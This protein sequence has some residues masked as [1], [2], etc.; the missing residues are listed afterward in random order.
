MYIHIGGSCSISDKIIVG[1]FSFETSTSQGTEKTT[2]E[3]LKQMEEH[4]RVTDLSEDLPKSFVVT[5]DGVYLS[6][7]STQTLRQR[8]QR[9]HKFTGTIYE[10]T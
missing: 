2:R 4:N 8:L 7:V 10:P 5:L 3:F 9:N 1:I 6:P